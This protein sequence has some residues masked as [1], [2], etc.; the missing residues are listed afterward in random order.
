MGDLNPTLVKAVIVVTFA[1]AFY[2]VAVLTEQRK[3]NISKFILVFLTAG[4]CCD[5]ASTAL[6]IAGSG[7]IPITVHGFL[8]Y[9]ALALMVTDVV[10]VWRHWARTHGAEKVPKGLHVYTR[11]A[12]GWWVVAYI[13]GAILAM[14]IET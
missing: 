6:M 12:Y 14:V 11:I 1:L 5:V 13:A 2:S 8:G 9:S 4:A 3:A 7:N 10:L